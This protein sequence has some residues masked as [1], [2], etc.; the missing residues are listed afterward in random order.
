MET[1]TV[2]V[3]PAECALLPQEALTAMS[4]LTEADD[5]D[6]RELV[7]GLELKHLAPLPGE[8]ER[9]LP[10]VHVTWAFL[11]PGLRSRSEAPRVEAA[12][13]L[14]VLT[15]RLAG[16][17]ILRRFKT[18]AL[19]ALR[20]LLRGAAAVG[21]RPR[22]GGGAVVEHAALG[23]V[24]RCQ[25]AA[26]RAVAAM[27]RDANGAAVI[28]G[29]ME[30]ADDAVAAMCVAL[31]AGRAGD[32]VEAVRALARVDVDA[33]WLR[34]LKASKQAGPQ[35]GRACERLLVEVEGLEVRW[36]EPFLQRCTQVGGGHAASVT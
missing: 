34:V 2:C 15:A 32:P 6:G 17:F 10:L 36:H 28:E 30:V 26:L 25:G 16:A 11:L 31:A 23:T 3:Y 5:C 24:A 33:V 1:H 9:L 13:Q 12:L 14:L 20:L 29:A 4:H 18:D 35:V 19:P 7:E 27:C 21:V 22:P 8:P